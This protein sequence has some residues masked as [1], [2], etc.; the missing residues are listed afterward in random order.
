MATTKIQKIFIRGVLAGTTTTRK[1]L[2]KCEG[3]H[4]PLPNGFNFSSLPKGIKVIPAEPIIIVQE[5][6]AVA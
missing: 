5:E 4:K 1:D 3:F 6:A 2:T